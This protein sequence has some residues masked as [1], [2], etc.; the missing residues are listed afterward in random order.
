MLGDIHKYGK[1]P[2]LRRRVHRLKAAAQAL[3]IKSANT[4][5]E[6]RDSIK[7][8]KTQTTYNENTYT[9]HTTGTQYLV[10]LQTR[11]SPTRK[12]RP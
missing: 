3:R 8:Q 9:M 5:K 10:E 7:L 6:I 12:R 11:S 1:C 4:G 2:A